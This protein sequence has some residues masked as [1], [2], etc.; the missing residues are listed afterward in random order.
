MWK[1]ADSDKDLKRA[2]ARGCTCL[3]L[4]KA[5]RRVTQIYDQCLEPFGLTVTQYGVL[6]HLATFDGSSIGALAEKLAMD[7]TTLTRNLQPL[8]RQG[9]VAV[10]P[11]RRDRRARCLH[12]TTSGRRAFER[13]KPGWAR[14]Q[15]HI[16]QVLGDIE[17]PALNAA[18]DR[19]LER[20]T[21]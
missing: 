3:R 15:G 8:Q 21:A 16:E 1:M 14:A 20:L 2:K 7:P 6:G 4:R 12:L 18:L 13:A 17:T 19:V 5:S 11:D 10:K 9:F